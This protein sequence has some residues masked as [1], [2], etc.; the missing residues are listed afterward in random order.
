[1]SA[2]SPST[3]DCPVV[4]AVLAHRSSTLAIRP[5]P[6][7]PAE[8][9][10]PLTLGLLT[11]LGPPA[12]FVA[13]LAV[14]GITIPAVLLG[15][16]G[17]SVLFLAVVLVVERRSP[18]VDLPTPSAL[19][20]YRGM[21][22][23]FIEGVLVGGGIVAGGWWLV[24][25]VSPWSGATGDGWVIAAAVLATDFAYYWIHRSLNHGR[26]QDPIRRWF[27]RCHAAH[28]RVTHLDFF[29][30]NLSSL[31]DT[32]M[33]GF[34][35]PLVVISAILGMDL[36]STLAAYGLVLMLQGTHHVNHTFRIGWL[37]F[38]FMDNHAHK[39]H[40]CPRGRLVNHGALFSLWDQAFGTYYED[41]SLSTN[42]MAHHRVA[43]PLKAVR[44]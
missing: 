33:T 10:S 23:V 43:L 16:A 11:H 20:V 36:A 26:G 12:A 2:S 9:G 6:D 32:A 34:Q 35:V 13:L 14:T 19:D 5:R 8:P 17:L 42:H 28:H 25:Q 21:V 39:L 37:R 41:W 44:S 3:P 40:H 15:F 22:L 24:S 29:R 31:P 7:V 18:N 4:R 38:V 1:M 27:R 30:G